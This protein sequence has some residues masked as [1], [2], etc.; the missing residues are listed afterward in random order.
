MALND[1]ITPKAKDY[2]KEQFG[3]SVG[4]QIL[5]NIARRELIK[6]KGALE[7]TLGKMRSRQER[8][9]TARALKIDFNP[10]YNGPVFK[11]ESKLVEV[12]KEGKT[13]TYL[14]LVTEVK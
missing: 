7:S 6:K 9:A 5:R 8:K 10:R 14:K 1:F 2:F 13:T 11:T 4:R 3:G 12:Q